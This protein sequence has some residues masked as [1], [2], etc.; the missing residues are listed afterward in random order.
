MRAM[1]KDPGLRSAPGFELAGDYMR[2]PNW[3][4]VGIHGQR[5]SP[6]YFWSKALPFR[7]GL[8]AALGGAAYQGVKDVKEEM[9]DLLQLYVLLEYLL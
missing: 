3:E 1:G 5:P 7:L 4:P 9:I 2:S 8:S 6:N